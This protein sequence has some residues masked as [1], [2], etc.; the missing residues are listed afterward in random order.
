MFVRIWRFF[1][2]AV[3][4]LSMGMA[5][6]HALEMPAKIGYDA[7][8]WTTL[9]HSLYQAYGTVGA[10]IEVGSVLAAILLAF[11]VY[12]RRPAFYFTVLG[13]A[14]LA[15]AFAAWVVFVAPVNAA[16]NTWT[17]GA[18]P[19]DWTRFRDQWE[20]AHAARFVLQLVGFGSLVVSV[21]AETP[22][23][24]AAAQPESRLAHAV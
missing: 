10:V 24:A 4:A 12:D 16:V 17:D 13:A 22:S 15:A 21:L 1:T 11:M 2:V 14:C 3:A 5:F 23:E 6:S 20:Y 9:Q 7:S 18:I 8:L 19:A